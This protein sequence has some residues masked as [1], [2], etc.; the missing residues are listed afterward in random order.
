VKKQKEQSMKCVNKLSAG[1]L[2]LGQTLCSAAFAVTLSGNTVD[3]SFDATQLGLF[4]QANV[5]GDTLYFTPVGFDVQ[6]FNGSGFTLANATMN[7]TVT[8]RDG[9]SFAGMGLAER[10]DYL[11]LGAGS[12]V[13][14]AGQIRAFDVAHPLTDLTAGISAA[15]PLVLQGT[16]THNWQADAALDLSAWRDART[17]NVTVENLLLASTGAAS[18]LAFVEKKFVGLTPLM[19]EVTPVPEADTWAMMLAGLGLVGWTTLRRRATSN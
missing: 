12:M 16:P 7:I 11:L 10:G 1:V 4:G 19:V 13:D 9:W 5:S 15:A 2:L 14:V 3:Y 18:S 8:A 6:S 17:V